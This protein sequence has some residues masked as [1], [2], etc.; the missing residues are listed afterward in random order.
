MEHMAGLLVFWKKFIF[1]VC[2]DSIGLSDDGRSECELGDR[3][4][5]RKATEDI[6]GIFTLS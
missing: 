4:D 1:L 6:R 2:M 5:V 3:Y